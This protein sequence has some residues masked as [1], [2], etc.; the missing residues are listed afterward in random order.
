MKNLKGPDDCILR[1]CN[2]II[3]FLVLLVVCERISSLPYGSKLSKPRLVTALTCVFLVLEFSGILL[4]LTGIVRKVK[5]GASIQAFSQDLE[6]NERSCG[7]GADRS[8][9]FWSRQPLDPLHKFGQPLNSPIKTLKVPNSI[10][11]PSSLCDIA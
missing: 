11:G 9:N 3:L 7:E 1:T 2:F 5:G 4:L 10:P 8:K 6:Q